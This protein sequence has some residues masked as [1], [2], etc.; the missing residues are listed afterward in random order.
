MN[1]DEAENFWKE[2]DRTAVRMDPEDLRKEIEAF[3]SAHKV[4]ALACAAG[5]F[6][7][8][9]PLEYTYADGCFYIF[10]EGGLKFRALRTN[11][12]VCLAVFEENP[13]FGHL[14]S[15]QASG[16]AEVIEPWS[17]EYLRVLKLRSIPAEALKKLPS[18]MYL[19]KVIPEEFDYLCS[20]LKQKGF[21]S[22]QQLILN[23]EGIGR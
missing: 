14:K 8:C 6:V 1:Y 3:L 2:K 11:Q 21:S 17:E 13:Q 18:P 23:Q 20:D 5:D 9:T 15:L 4:C 16:I 7:R 12:H 22:R 19:I 10:S